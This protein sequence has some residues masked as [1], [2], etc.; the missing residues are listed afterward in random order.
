M[1]SISV[2]AL[3]DTEADV[4]Y[5]SGDE[6]LQCLSQMFS[7]CKCTAETICDVCLDRNF[8]DDSD[9]VDCASV[10]R[11]RDVTDSMKKL[12]LEQ[13]YLRT[14]KPRNL[15]SVFDA[16][17]GGSVESGVYTYDLPNDEQTAIETQLESLEETHAFEKPETQ[18]LVQDAFTE[19]AQ[20]Q[21]LKSDFYK[22]A[23]PQLDKGARWSDLHREMKND[24]TMQKVWSVFMKR[25]YTGARSASQYNHVAIEAVLC[26]DCDRI[27]AK[28]TM[29]HVYYICEYDK[30][31]RSAAG[32]RGLLK[33]VCNTPVV[34]GVP[35]LKNKNVRSWLTDQTSPLC[36]DP[37]KDITALQLNTDVNET[38]QEKFNA[39]ELL[40]YIEEN[41]P[42]SLEILVA[43]YRKL[44]TE[45][46]PN[47]RAWIALSTAL[48]I[49]KRTFELYKSTLKGIAQQMTMPEYI[50]SR[51]QKYSGGSAEKVKE[52][53]GYN[54]VS[55]QFLLTKLRRWF[56]G[57][58]KHNV[59]VFLGP[60]NTGKSMLCENL[61][62]MTGGCFL[63]WNDNNTFWKQGIIGARTAYLDDVS[64]QCW[65]HLDVHER[66]TIDGGIVAVN[67]KFSEAV[68]TRLPP[69]LFTT[70]YDI[71]QMT[72]FEYLNNR[73]QWIEFSHPIDSTGLKLTPADCAA[74]IKEHLAD[75]DLD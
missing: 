11:K 14:K 42:I 26:T 52:L 27:R 49:A 43:N 47:A 12:R 29:T 23:Y 24:K 33:K 17:E 48:P 72:E 36:D 28:H 55:E 3:F 75:L 59:L 65:R 37:E 15:S 4:D 44:A 68:E 10:Y 9:Q 73:L 32:L 51:I 50:Q 7:T 19:K 5:D 62:I 13:E 8:I 18:Q 16:L 63:S 1:A 64:L 40:I 22:F 39:E 54:R 21:L 38:A 35:H 70:N 74:W 34:L 46:D 45:G 66:R 6:A 30:T 25:P 71:R 56:T 60:G 2:E 67:K 69:S 31:S 61:T 53:L 41:K 20:L 58:I 57:S